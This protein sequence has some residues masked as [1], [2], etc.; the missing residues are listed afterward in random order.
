MALANT[1]WIF[2]LFKY[3]V[4][5]CNKIL[6]KPLLGWHTLCTG[7]LNIQFCNGRLAPWT[8]LIYFILTSCNSLENLDFL[9]HVG[10]APLQNHPK[11][12]CQCEN[13][14]T[15]WLLCVVLN[16]FRGEG[17]KAF[18]CTNSINIVKC[19]PMAARQKCEMT[20]AYVCTRRGS[21]LLNSQTFCRTFGY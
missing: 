10:S 16:V 6:N 14:D 20:K 9:Q 11:H 1:S 8:W 19:R 18:A 7:V 21:F 12:M 17:Q 4:C 2:P 13:I 5:C 3:E 15:V